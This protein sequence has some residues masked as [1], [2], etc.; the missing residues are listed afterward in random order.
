MLQHSPPCARMRVILNVGR[1]P[2]IDEAA[3]YAALKE[4]R[5]GGAIIDTWYVYPS[6]ANPTPHPG[7][8]PFHT[9]DNCVLTPHM[10]GWT[11]GTIRRRQE[12]MADNIRRLAA[13]QPLENMV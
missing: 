8:L 5:I 11:H 7:T 4:R 1:G 9:L 12:T 10:S 13:G 3:L 2:V 6:A